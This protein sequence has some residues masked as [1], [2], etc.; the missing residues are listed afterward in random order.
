M[1]WN[2]C[3]F[4]KKIAIAFFLVIGG[5]CTSTLLSQHQ[6]GQMVDSGDLAL[7]KQNY[8]T[9]LALSESDHLRWTNVLCNWLG[10]DGKGALKL[11]TDETQ[12]K[13]GKWLASDDRRTLEKLV[14]G[15]A[16]LLV[17]MAEPHKALH[18][19]ARGIE[20]K[21]HAGQMDE[22]RALYASQS[23]PA[24]AAV[25]ALLGQARESADKAAD[26]DR[27]SYHD[28][29]T[30]AVQWSWL[31]L[32]VAVAVAV[33]MGCLLLRTVAA[34]LAYLAECASRIAADELSLR[35]DIHRSDEI[36]T[37]ALSLNQMTA[38]LEEKIQV[39]RHTSEQA[40]E[41][42]RQV[43]EAL[44]EARHREEAIT[45]M[46]STLE[47]VTD[48]SRDIADVLTRETETMASLVND[49]VQGCEEQR[50]LLG[51]SAS[52]MA[53]INSAAESIAHHAEQSSADASDTLQ[54][55]QSGSSVVSNS[56]TAISD[57]GVI[58]QKL[59]ENMQE[60]GRQ[61]EAI[62]TVMNLIS[63]IADQTN[64]LALNAAIEAAR[65]GE[66]GRGFAVVADEVRKL[67]EK[68]MNATRE[69]GDSIHS[70]Q[71]VVQ[72]G[73][74][75]M[76]EVTGAVQRSTALV[77]E[78]GASLQEIVALANANASSIQTIAAASVEQSGS[79]QSISQNLSHVVDI[80]SNV[81]NEMGKA[82]EA[83]HTV[84]E[85]TQKM[86]ELVEK[87]AEAKQ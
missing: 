46:L 27:A 36:G 5:M 30:V 2:N 71:S 6:Q 24:S 47:E 22:A 77:N 16:E 48:S 4:A 81:N 1:F 51:E 55:A 13:L 78:S 59:A 25:V 41:S 87:A 42:A 8:A 60:L 53:E 58:G 15:M 70:I 64:L 32:A 23:K 43:E 66:A 39:A 45:H 18:N 80:A 79:C 84:V 35:A 17:R 65:A 49:A 9:L 72:T 40:M 54:K 19:S 52:G 85:M 62:G 26:V 3:S 56:L 75:N 63:D 10:Q 57:V 14:P 7:Q 44:E 76:E 21:A 83:V 69:V 82:L 12:C 20:A 11:E 68:T 28:A 73:I 61:A 33:G 74:S 29:S 31:L 38:S 50:Q 34:P 86:R 37:L 67:A